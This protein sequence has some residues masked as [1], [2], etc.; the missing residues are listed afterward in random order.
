MVRA[1]EVETAL[2]Q[3]QHPPTQ[4]IWGATDEA[5]LNKVLKKPTT[6]NIPLSY[7]FISDFAFQISS[8]HL[9]NSLDINS[10][11]KIYLV[12]INEYIMDLLM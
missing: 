2:G 7:N 1:F 12:Y 5:V 4:R 3:F 11:L 8:N 6:K 9:N 10:L